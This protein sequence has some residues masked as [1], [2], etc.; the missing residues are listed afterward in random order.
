MTRELYSNLRQM[1]ADPDVDPNTMYSSTVALMSHEK[2]QQQR[3][4]MKMMEDQ[5]AMKDTLEKMD[6]KLDEISDEVSNNPVVGFGKFMR[7]HPTKS[8]VI[9]AVGFFLTF[10]MSIYEIRHWVFGL[11]ELWLGL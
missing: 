1:A 9:I 11:F 7:E 4:N 6:K 2:E 8:K 5:S 3:H 10:G